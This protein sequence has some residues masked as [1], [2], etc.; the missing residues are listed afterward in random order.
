MLQVLALLQGDILALGFDGLFA[1]LHE[2]DI[3]KAHPLR[4]GDQAVEVRANYV[5]VC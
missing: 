5:A 1:D 3:L 4:E 2:H